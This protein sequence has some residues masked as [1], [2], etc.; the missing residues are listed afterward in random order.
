MTKKRKRVDMSARLPDP[1]VGFVRNDERHISREVVHEGRLI[2][3]VIADESSDG[4]HLVTSDGN[5]VDHYGL[6]F[7]EALER[8]RRSF[9]MAG[10]DDGARNGD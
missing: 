5:I 3:A 1:P 6:T 10:A 7:E 9:R 4:F 8:A 2:W